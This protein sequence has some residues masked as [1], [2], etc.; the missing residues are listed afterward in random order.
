M[1]KDTWKPHSSL[2]E[3]PTNLKE[4]IDWVLRVT[5]RD[6]KKNEKPA[7]AAAA[8]AASTSNGPHC[9]CYL[10]KAI[11]DL[12]YDAK[13]P[14]FPGPSPK[15]NWDDILLTEEQSIVKPVLQD[16]GLVNSDSTSATSTCAGGTEVIGTLIDQLALGLEKWVGWQEGDTCCLKGTEGIGRKCD[17]P[18]GVGVGGNCCGTSGSGTTPCHQCGTCGPSGKN[19]C[20]QSAY[21]R[22]TTP[23]SSPP[24]AEFYWPTISSDAD[25]VH[26]LARIFLGSVCLIW[27]GLSQLGFLTKEG[28]GGTEKRWKD[29][30][31]SDVEKG[32]GSFMAAMGYDLE[33]LNGSGGTGGPAKTGDFVQ[34]LL[35]GK[36]PDEKKGI[37]WKEFQGDS[38]SK[39]SVA[40]YYSSIYEKAKTAVEKKL[41]TE[42]L[43][44]QY[45]LLVL[46]I[47]ASGYFR[48]GS[49][50][51]KNVTPPA[52]PAPGSDT[53]KDTPSS[54]KP[55][56]I[57]EILYW[58]SALPYSE[59]YR[60]LVDRMKEKTDQVTNGSGETEIKLYDEKAAGNASTTLQRKDITHYLLAACGYCPLVLIGI[61]GT[62]EREV[63]TDTPGGGE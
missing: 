8:A 27:S 56:T 47:L 13:D 63:K 12:L 54:R 32:L 59:K 38:T 21:C 18:G 58:L 41:K 11:K 40:E 9:L 15:R 49:A 55:R 28:S 25:K 2:T 20:Y 26:L 50:G 61:Q 17:C 52:K 10:A 33:R 45:P 19:K 5:G 23:P 4:A 35:T 3:A 29:D 39:D 31:L 43:C 46:H 24:T 6:G 44:E 7:A 1:S 22:P 57:R 53:K 51:A 60:K 48:A 30:T 34:Q 42:Q 37:Q 16:L 36:H 14:G 62:I